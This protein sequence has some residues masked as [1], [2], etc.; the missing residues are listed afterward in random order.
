MRLFGVETRRFWL[1]RA[2]R[3]LVLFGIAV[4]ALVMVITAVHSKVHTGSRNIAICN[5]PTASTGTL[6]APPPNDCVIST[7]TGP[8]D[9]RYNLH[10][11]LADSIRG[12]GVAFMLLSVVFGS[13]FIGA[14]FVSGSL[15]GQLTFE[16]RRVRVFA[17]KAAALAVSAALVTLFLLTVVVLSL[18][19]V[20][21]TRGVVGH[22]DSTWYTRRAADV[23][24]VVATCAAISTFAFGI[25]TIARRTVAGVITF[26]ALGFIVEPALSGAVHFL[27]GKTPIHAYIATTI[28]LFGGQGDSGP[29]GFHSLGPSA[30]VAAAWT[31]AVLV[32]AAVTFAR[33]EIR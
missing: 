9:D 8:I 29:P 3:W 4:I 17:A 30:L 11:S 19:L 2:V 33:R 26:L 13:T 31:V 25:T 5:G 20:A 32:V 16:P 18:A 15:G 21:S 22:L 24:R 27:Q 12:S 7:R 14:D 23:G 1:R 6:N 28:N 10:Q